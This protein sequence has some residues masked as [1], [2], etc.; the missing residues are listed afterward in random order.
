MEWDLDDMTYSEDSE[1]EDPEERE[2]RLWVE[3]YNYDR[4]YDPYDIHPSATKEA[5]QEIR[6]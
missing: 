3:R 6:G 5:A 4:G 2:N 1:W